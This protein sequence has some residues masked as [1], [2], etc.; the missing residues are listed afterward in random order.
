MLVMFYTAKYYAF[1]LSTPHHCL[2]PATL[3]EPTGK[4]RDRVESTENA[5]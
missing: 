2:T 1:F 5:L 3:Q 4:S